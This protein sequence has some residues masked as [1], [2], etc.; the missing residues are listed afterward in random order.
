MTQ[1]KHELFDREELRLL[2]E[3]AVR[4]AVTSAM[5]ASQHRCRFDVPE[6]SVREVGH[7][8]GMLRDVGGG[9]CAKGIEAV[10]ENHKWLRNLREKS[11]K[12]TM[13]VIV[14]L[15]T[16]LTGGALAALWNGI[17]ANVKN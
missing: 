1:T 4:S 16:A 3:T 2:V 10:R 7:V 8:M 5:A 17:K 12:A 14:V 11:N 15:L 13:T 6:D 9:D